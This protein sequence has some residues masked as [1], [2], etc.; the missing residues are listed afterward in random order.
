MKRHVSTS[1]SRA[2]V[3][4]PVAALSG[5]ASGDSRAW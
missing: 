1:S 3:P 4:L 2:V 5:G